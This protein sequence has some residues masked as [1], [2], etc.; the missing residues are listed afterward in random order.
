MNRLLQREQNK[1]E[2]H[3]WSAIYVTMCGTCVCN[4]HVS[5]LHM[6]QTH[7]HTHTC[8]PNGFSNWSLSHFMHAHM[9]QDPFIL[10]TCYAFNFNFEQKKK[11]NVKLSAMVC[12]YYKITDSLWFQ[13]FYF[14]KHQIDTFL[15]LWLCLVVLVSSKL[16]K[17]CHSFQC[18]L[19]DQRVYQ[20]LC[21]CDFVHVW[22]RE[23]TLLPLNRLLQHA[24]YIILQSCI[25]FLSTHR[26]QYIFYRSHTIAS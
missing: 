9:Y 14:E 12:I 2:P 7:T 21:V 4:M 1:N 23:G 19:C 16:F 18:V 3:I 11:C 20:R 10:Q 17:W 24:I 13:I 25:A 26:T 15:P 8:S 5:W 22:K 6:T